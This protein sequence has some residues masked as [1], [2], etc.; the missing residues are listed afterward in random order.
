MLLGCAKVFFT[1]SLCNPHKFSIKALRLPHEGVTSKLL[2][3]NGNYINIA[4]LITQ[5]TH[6]FAWILIQS[7]FQRIFSLLFQRPVG[8]LELHAGLL[9]HVMEIL[10]VWVAVLKVGLVGGHLKIYM[11]ADCQL[12]ANNT[13]NFPIKCLQTWSWPFKAFRVCTKSV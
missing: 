6:I 4:L 12:Y 13:L 5:T 3:S 2:I 7:S 11:S 8:N 9:K 1:S 10:D